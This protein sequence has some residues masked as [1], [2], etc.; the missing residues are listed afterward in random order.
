MQCIPD[1]GEMNIDD[2]RTTSRAP[3]A[4]S[5]PPT[6][7]NLSESAPLPSPAVQVGNC[8]LPGSVVPDQQS[9]YIRIGELD[10]KPTF[11]TLFITSSSTTPPFSCCK[12]L[13]AFS[14]CRCNVL[15]VS[16]TLTIRA[17]I[18][19][20][21]PFSAGSKTF[22]SSSMSFFRNS[23]SALSIAY[24]RF[25]STCVLAASP[26]HWWLNLRCFLLHSAARIEISRSCFCSRVFRPSLISCSR[27]RRTLRA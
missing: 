25:L 22:L 9:V 11:F 21:L 19:S 24:P 26:R 23:S 16:L 5:M 13:P 15:P 6:P 4:S 1:T 7:P 14:N 12:L 8:N 10:G 18:S 3:A 2:K 20:P 17:H 27:P